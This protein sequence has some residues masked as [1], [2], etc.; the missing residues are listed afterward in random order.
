MPGLDVNVMNSFGRTP[1][2]LAIYWGKEFATKKLLRYPRVNIDTA[3]MYSESPLINAACQG[4]VEIVMS[5]LNRAK[6]VDNYIDKS[7]RLIIHW[8]FINNMIPALELTLEKQIS[9][10]N[11]LDNR[12]MIALYYAAEGGDLTATRILLKYGA[13]A[14][15]RN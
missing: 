1:L 8:A 14:L 10:I 15:A 7:G 3:E 13:D 5:I 6:D 4:W 11:S 9:M 12:K 2:T